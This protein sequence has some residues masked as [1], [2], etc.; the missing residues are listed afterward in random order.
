MKLG[1]VMD[2]IGSINIKKDSTFEMLWQAQQLDWDITYLE[3]NDL[4]IKEGVA[5]GHKRPIKVFQ[6]KKKW[7]ELGDTE[8]IELGSLD[9]ILMRQDPPFNMEYIYST[10]ILELAQEQGVSVF[11]NPA[12]L[13]DCN[14]KAYTA[15]FPQCCP[16]TMITRNDTDIRVFLAEHQ[17]IILKPLD[18]MGGASVFRVQQGESNISVIIETLTAHGN[19]YT[20]AQQYIPEIKQGDKRIL[21]IDGEP[22]PYALA[23]IPAEGEL[24]G[25]L[26]AGATGVAQP[27]SDRDAQIAKTVGVE[28]KKRG[29]VFAGLDVIGDYL[30]EINITSPTGIKELNQQ[31][32][33]NIARDLLKVIENLVKHSQLK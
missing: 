11:N 4:F 1:V 32:D 18:G 33:L 21:M 31:Y 14:E 6:D 29:I 9:A 7:F 16:A 26:A 27:L 23:R 5:Y 3:L 13:R 20:M 2:P 8:T 24:R 12:A 25:N 22:V 28:L 10:Y 17:D 19:Q 30:T 15:W